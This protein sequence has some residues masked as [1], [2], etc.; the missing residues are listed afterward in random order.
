MG[1]ITLTV[2][3]PTFPM[4]QLEFSF[5]QPLSEQAVTLGQ[6]RQLRVCDGMGRE[7]FRGEGGRHT[8]AVS[9]AL[10]WHVV[11]IHD[12]Q[13]GE[14]ER[15]RFRVD[16]RSEI[17]DAENR[18]GTMF[19]TIH[20]VLEMA[21]AER[22]LRSFDGEKT[23]RKQCVTSRGTWT[24][25]QGGRYFFDH[26][27]DST[28]FFTENATANGMVWDFGCPVEKERPYHFEWRWG[29]EFSKR[30]AG[31]AEIFARQPIMNDVEHQYINGLFL[32]WQVSGDDAWMARHLDTAL[33][34][35]TYTRNNPYTW[36]EKF[37]LIHRPFTLDLWDFQSDFDSALVGGDH[38]Q[39]IPGVSQFGVFYGDNLS[40]AFACRNLARMLR[41]A[42]RADEAGEIELFGEGLQQRTDALCWNG[43]FY[44]MHVPENPAFERDF[45]IDAEDVV[46]LSNTMAA[47]YNIGEEKARGIIETYQRIRKELPSN[48]RA[49]FM[50]M[51]PHFPRGFHIG[52]GFYV[53]G[54][55]SGLV[56]GELARASF[57][58]GYECYGADVLRRY[59]ELVEPFAPYIQG[60]LRAFE[61]QPPAREFGPVDLRPHANA[62][63][64]CDEAQDGWMG[65]PGNDM[66]ELPVGQQTF[67]TIPFEVIP[68]ETNENRACVR[69]ANN[70]EGYVKE[71]AIPVNATASAIYLLH[72][73]AGS[74]TVMGELM[75]EYLDGTTSHVYIQR[76]RHVLSA[77]NPEDPR[78]RRSIPDVTLG[79]V[80]ETKVFSRVGLTLWGWNN[81]QPEKRIARLKLLAS[82]ENA[83][84][85]AVVGVTLSDAP[86]W[87]PPRDAFEG[88]NQYWSASAVAC[89]M[90]EGLAGISDRDRALQSVRIKPGWLAAGVDEATAC[91]KYEENGTY[92]RYH[93]R[94]EAGRIT[95]EIAAS[96]EERLVELL[97]PEG[98]SPKRL[99]LNGEATRYGIREIGNS[100]Y[101][102]V[103]SRSLGALSLALELDSLNKA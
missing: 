58:Y 77:W 91:I 10:G 64:R 54:A 53:N 35:V 68:P 63:L 23:I 94:R 88:P 40:M 18:F 29:R 71:A 39:A 103:P 65:E 44:Q 26:I 59:W 61:H 96:G 99:V 32:A 5:L 79:W 82:R 4:I 92:V 48:Y 3:T 97:L 102:T 21:Y 41:V 90:G 2:H 34:A 76:G 11:S 27:K 6:A 13:G 52:P 47:N 70:L 89:A 33:A 98:A 38:M 28:D 37:Q 30:V 42:G 81:P 69:L 74:A 50:T 36:S 16:C 49:E 9:G 100:R 20:H 93:Y 51:W 95:L 83:A 75:V 19:D 55:V 7:Y 87:L 46:S 78:P 57:E 66:R 101:V 85:W 14:L 80:G 45:G 17:R 25:A 62:N 60:G 56:A 43:R 73:S 8:F 72:A 12:D 1:T 15:T 84:K 24:G 67:E 22:R 31:G 86:V